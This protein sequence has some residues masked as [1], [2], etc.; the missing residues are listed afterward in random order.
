MCCVVSAYLNRTFTFK[1][2]SVNK[3]PSLGDNRFRTSFV[4]MSSYN[5]EEITTRNETT[6]LFAERV[7]YCFEEHMPQPFVCFRHSK[8]SP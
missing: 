1:A 3:K 6:M 2:G 8:R 7:P 4:N 5:Y